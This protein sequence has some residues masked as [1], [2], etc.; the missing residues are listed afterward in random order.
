[1]KPSAIIPIKSQNI[2]TVIAGMTDVSTKGTARFVFKGVPYSIACKTGTAQVVTIAQDDRYDAKKLARKHHDHA[3]FIA[4]APARNPR[5]ALAVL[6]ENGG[7]GAQAAAPI[8]RQ[9]V[10]YWLTGENSLNLPPPKGVPLIT[11]KRNH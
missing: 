5:I 7:F 6:V 4:F 3:L 1:M 10:D 8:A 9:L 11:P 2:E